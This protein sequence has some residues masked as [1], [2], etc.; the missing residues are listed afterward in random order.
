MPSQML[1]T[2]TLLTALGCAIIGGVFFAFS[3]FVMSALAR[4]P[5]AHGIAAMQSINITVINPL[6][7]LV[8]LGTAVACLVLAV[9]PLFAWHTPRAAYLVAGA[10]LYLVGTFLVTMVCNVPRNEAL[11]VVDPVSVAGAELWADYLKTWTAWNHVRTAAGLVAAI[12]L[13]LAL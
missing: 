3:V 6:F 5:P 10:L 8:F 7:M 4:L 1:Y 2:L 12:F 11:A 13:I 9:G